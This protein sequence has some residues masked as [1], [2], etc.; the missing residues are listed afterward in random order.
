MGNV[1]N[2]TLT[3]MGVLLDQEWKIPRKS[4]NSINIFYS[5]EYREVSG[6][7]QNID[8]HPPLPLESVSSPHT[9]GV[10]VH[11]RRAVRGWGV[12]ILEDASH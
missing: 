7:F 5:E 1:Q 2:F 11:T 8:P 4:W 12:N 10:G 3:T 6:V 9:K